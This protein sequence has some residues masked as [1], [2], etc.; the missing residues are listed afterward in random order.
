MSLLSFLR[1]ALRDFGG[2]GAVTPTSKYVIKSVLKQLP[3]IP[4]DVLEYGPG[5]GV[6]TKEL[7]KRLS[8]DGRLL[9]IERN[10]E[11]AKKT[12]DI[13]DARLVAVEGD[14]MDAASHAAKNH[15][16][17]FDAVV[18]NVPFTMFPSETK[19][20]IVAKTYDLLK[21][22]GVFVIFQYSRLMLPYLKEKFSV[23][24]SYDP[25]NLP[26]Y[27]IMTARK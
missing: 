6:L 3:A 20:E 16:G 2:V 22:G 7:L 25:R 14:V 12:A 11:F 15:F 17:L 1:V 27:F 19:K 4:G 18:S 21:P 9:A 23:R 24:V 10:A 8:P 5:D 26:P 13:A